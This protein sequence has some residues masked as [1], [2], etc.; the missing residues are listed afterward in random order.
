MAKRRKFYAMKVMAAIMIVAAVLQVTGFVMRRTTVKGLPEYDDAPDIAIPLMLINDS[1]PVRQAR[2]EAEWEAALEEPGM[3]FGDSAGAVSA[4]AAAEPA[5]PVD[6]AQ[7]PVQASDAQAE[8]AEQSAVEA[9][10]VAQPEVQTVAQSDAQTAIQPEDQPAVQTASVQEAQPASEAGTVQQ[11]A[12]A[13]SAA[14]VNVDEHYFD[15]TLFIGDSKTDGMR[16]WARLGEAQYF[17]GTNYS[18]FNVFDKTTSDKAFENA[19]LDEVL[20]RFTYD[21]IYII[22]GYN[23]SGYPYNNLMKKYKYVLARVHEAQP[24]ARIILH[25]VMHASKKVAQRESY[26]SVKNLEKIND[27]L[28]ELAAQYPGILYYVDCNAPFCDSEGNLLESVS[29]DGEHL[30]SEYVRQWAQEIIKRAVVPQ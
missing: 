21:Q 8:I 18:V 7:A 22:L 29:N 19:T 1:S 6:A 12:P 5:A 24:Q 13:Q 14:P 9:Q 20:G 15:H 25:G 11:D 23:E 28:R 16:M 10:T 26:Y 30:T 2:E 27:G 3:L 17:C 4:M